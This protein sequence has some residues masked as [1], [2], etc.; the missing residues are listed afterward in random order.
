MKIGVLVNWIKKQSKHTEWPKKLK[1]IEVEMHRLVKKVEMHIPLLSFLTSRLR[2]LAIGSLVHPRIPFHCAFAANALL[3][4][5][6]ASFLAKTQLMS[7]RVAYAANII[8]PN[9]QHG[10]I[11]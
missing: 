10:Y 5:S 9:T 6:V 4:F 3:S 11:D 8:K 7:A 1:R 2:F